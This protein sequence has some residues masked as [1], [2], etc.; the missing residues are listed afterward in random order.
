MCTTYF[1]HIHP[2][3]IQLLQDPSIFLPPNLPQRIQFVPSM[4]AGPS[5]EQP[6]RNCILKEKGLFFSP[7]RD[8]DSCV[9]P[10]STWQCWLAWSYAG[11]VKGNRAAVNSWVKPSCQIRMTRFHACPPCP[12]TLR[13]F[14]PPLVPEP[15]GKGIWYKCPIYG[16]ELHMS[17]P[18]LRWSIVSFLV[19]HHPWHKETS[20]MRS[21]LHLSV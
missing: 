21:E 13:I 8:G 4:S 20:L 18:S 6:V 1:D 9:P 5:T 17:S 7:A 10:T 11:H 2:L 16:W 14:L 19:K 3:S 12:V 15:W